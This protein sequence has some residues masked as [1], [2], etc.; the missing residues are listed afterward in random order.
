M[1]IFLSKLILC[2][3][4]LLTVEFFGSQMASAGQTEYPVP[5]NPAKTHYMLGIIGYNYTDEN[6]A[7]FTVNGAGGGNV[8]LSS[9]TSGGGGTVCCVLLSKNNVWPMQVIVRWQVGGCRVYHEDRNFGY[10]QFYYKEANV[11]VERGKSARPSDITVHFYKNG[12]VRV[13]LS[14]GGDLPLLKLEKDR[15]VERKFPECKLTDPVE[16][17]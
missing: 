4:L 17:L 9:P 3:S 8:R 16:Y 15:A 10:S 6:I 7:A 2:A 1:N 12:A 14:E 5:E 11:T 13:I